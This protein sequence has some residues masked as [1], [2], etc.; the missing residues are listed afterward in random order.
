M[1]P[2]LFG[3]LYLLVDLLFLALKHLLQRVVA[4]AK[5]KIR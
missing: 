5:R 1:E 3:V 2:I 4:D